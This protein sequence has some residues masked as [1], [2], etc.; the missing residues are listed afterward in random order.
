VLIACWSVKG[1]SGTTVVACS[2]ALL[3]ARSA[4]TGALLADLAGDAPAALGLPDPTGPGIDDWV[5][6]DGDV[7]ADALLRVELEATAGLRLLPKGRHDCAGPASGAA[8]GV[9]ADMPPVGRAQALA[10]A[11][12]DDPRPVVADC[13]RLDVD[14][15][16]E[17]AMA[18][19]AGAGLS[20]L[21]VRPCYL[22][23]RRAVS[24]PLRPS[25]VV[26]VREEG[27]ALGRDDVEAVLGVPVR[28]EVEVDPSVARAVDAGLLAGRIPRQLERALRKAS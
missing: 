14:H 4:P 12:S 23:L 16:D 26:L 5:H 11:L 28:C 13:G 25:G 24:A 19:A 21:V 17:V 20:L 27:R 22:S 7:D 10:A 6:A 9:A 1:G 2:L 18:V 15:A 3:L 8:G